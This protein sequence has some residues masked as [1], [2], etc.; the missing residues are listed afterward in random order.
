MFFFPSVDEFEA[1][2]GED[3]GGYEKQ[4]PEGGGFVEE[5]DSYDYGSDGTD[6]GPDGVGGSDGDCLDGF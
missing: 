1:E 3:E 6:A 2:D 5:D 4:S